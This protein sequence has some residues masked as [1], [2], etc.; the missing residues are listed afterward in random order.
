MKREIKYI[1]SHLAAFLLIGLVFSGCSSSDD[2]D[3][4]LGVGVQWTVALK[5]ANGESLASTTTNSTTRTSDDS[6]VD[7][8]KALENSVMKIYDADDRLVRRYEPLAD[9]PSVIY[10]TEGDYRVTVLAGESLSPADSMED[11][12]FEGESNFSISAATSASIAINCKM[13]N[14]AVTLKFDSSIEDNIEDGYMAVVA[15]ASEI[16]DLILDDSY[17]HK[18]VFTENGIVYFIQPDGESNLAWYFKGT[19]KLSDDVV[20]SS[21]VFTD[22]VAGES[23]C[24]TFSYEKGLMVSTTFVT[25]DTSTDDFNDIF[26]FSPQPTIIGTD[27]NISATQIADGRDF[28]INVDAIYELNN[29]NLSYGGTTIAPFVD[30]EVMEVESLSYVVNSATSGL[31]T[32]KNEYF[33]NIGLGGDQTITINA[34]DIKASKTAKAFC[35][36]TSGATGLSDYDFWNNSATISMTVVD[37][38]ITAS[39]TKVEFRTKG[40]SDWLSYDIVAGSTSNSYTAK[41]ESKWSTAKANVSGLSYYTLEEGITPNTEYECRLVVDGEAR[42]AAT[43]TTPNTTQS[44]PSADLDSSSLP[45]W[46]SD[47]ESESSTTWGSGNNT[48]T[49]KLCTQGSRGDASYCA[50]MEATELYGNFAAGN[51]FY[52]QFT[53][54]GIIKQTGTVRFGQAFS[55]S[56]RPK[57]FKLRYS[58]TVGQDAMTVNGVSYSHDRGRIYFAIVDWSDRHSVTAGSGDPE[59]VWDPETAT[60]TSEGKIIGYAS[61][62]IDESTDS[63]MHDLELPIYYYDTVTKPS[64]SISIVISCATSA[65]GDYMTGSTDSRLWVDDFQFGY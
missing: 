57:S 19:R 64:N 7:Y 37:S 35:V 20:S 56:V 61:Y 62:Y 14:N 2:V 65:Y 18:K 48:W 17:L 60:S 54:N 11:L 10:L 39:N 22:V 58:A 33:S 25:V 24:L 30:G 12:T 50:Y 21:G 59:G 49:S 41:T 38:N 31:L 16:N 6:D 55:W 27:F 4:E 15:P 8:S 44:I 46:G 23:N 9:A 63:N 43:F 29:V 52:G 28:E 1:M 42:T 47:G 51:L 34:T 40:A 3:A 32:I 5:S 36:T 53:F 13:L 26:E 45:C